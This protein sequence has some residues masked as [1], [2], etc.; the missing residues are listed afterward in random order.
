[1]RTP[2]I[3]A[4]GAL[5]ER[6]KQP[7]QVKT[8]A[9][10]A[11]MPPYMESFLAHLRLLVGVPFEYLIPDPRLLPDESIRFFYLDRSWADRLVDGALVVGQIGSREQAH[12]HGQAPA[13]S[14]R[15]DQSER[16][17]RSLQRGSDFEDAKKVVLAQP[18]AADNVTGLVLR[19]GAVS[20]WPHMDVRAY[21][22]VIA[23]PFD[24]SASTSLSLQLKPLR[25]E[26]LSPGVLFALFQG[27][28]KLVILEEPHHGVQFGIRRMGTHLK[29]PLRDATGNQL[30]TSGQA[31]TVEVP[32]RP[33]PNGVVR[34][35]ALRDA[36]MAQRA[37]H[38]TA[39]EQTGSAALAI[40]VLD[41]PWRQRFEGTQDLADTGEEP[42]RRSW[43]VVS[44]TVRREALRTNVKTILGGS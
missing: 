42:G 8:D 40:S 4:D 23:E 3:T 22:E 10:E 21:R 43:T 29:V 34:V 27:V 14:Q 37:T 5:R 15:L 36:L 16:M 7:A 13:L 24:T 41:P 20:G 11:A 28:P 17:V 1:M 38:P 30:V 31:V 33:G 6:M 19:S 26:R 44:Q 25:I 2:L 39:V 18:S 9:P 32:M 35:K 12:Y